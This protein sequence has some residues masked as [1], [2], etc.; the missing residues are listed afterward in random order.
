MISNPSG[1]IKIWRKPLAAAVAALLLTEAPVAA[2]AVFKELSEEALADMRGKFVAGGRVQYF[3]MTVTTQWTHSEALADT[4][5][6]ASQTVATTLSNGDVGYAGSRHREA[7]QGPGAQSVADAQQPAA[8]VHEVN[9]KFEVD[10]SGADTRVAYTVGGT[11][12]Q[13]VPNRPAPAPN[14]ALGQIQGA[15][16][17]IQVEGSDNVV[18]NNVGYA[19]IP[20]SAAPVLTDAQ[21]ATVAPA[22]QTFVN[23]DVVTQVTASNGIG[24]TITAQG[25][26]ITQ[27]LG[28]NPI[29]NGSQLLQSVQ[30]KADGQRIVNDLMLQVAFDNAVAQRDSVRFRADRIMNLL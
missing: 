3:G 27:H 29:T 6:S 2:A 9:L 17:A 19:V 4:T 13:E 16:Q 24:Y 1:F 20:A 8:S 7:P 28:V 12:G 25:N 15:V 23:G 5:R 22:D 26:Q 10:N 18:R 21:V 30:L 14:A 11:L